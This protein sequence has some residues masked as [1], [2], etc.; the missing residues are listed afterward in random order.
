MKMLLMPLI[1]I[2]LEATNKNKAPETPGAFK[3]K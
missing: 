1:S 3:K 2:V